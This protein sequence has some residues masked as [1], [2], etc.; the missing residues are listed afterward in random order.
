M[1]GLLAQVWPL[2]SRLGVTVAVLVTSVA[3]TSCAASDGMIEKLYDSTRAYNRSLRWG[4]WDRAAEY[5]P[6]ASA[7]AFMDSHQAVEERLVVIDYQMTR[8][9]VDKA[10]GV[11]ASQVDISW[12][13]DRELV[14]R[15]TRVNH[16]WQWYEGQWVLVDERRSGG[17]PLAIFAEVGT[18]EDHP[19]LPGLDAFREEYAI[20]LNPDEKRK[21][22]RE[23]RKAARAKKN[24]PSQKYSLDALQSMPTE[25][26]PASF[27]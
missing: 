4:D 19:Y 17:K 25:R 7:N 18:G 2:L 24:Q 13:T 9:E 11:A 6:Q 10:N 16:I 8:I 14:V 3:V 27:N 20:G 22:E 21:R 12:H 5:I 15:T 1:S 23:Q 26:R